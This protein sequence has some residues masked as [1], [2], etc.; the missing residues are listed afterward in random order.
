[1]DFW[2]VQLYP[3]NDAELIEYHW[4]GGQVSV[5]PDFCESGALCKIQTFINKREV[6]ILGFGYSPSVI[7]MEL[8]HAETWTLI[9]WSEGKE[10]RTSFF[11]KVRSMFPTR[12][13]AYP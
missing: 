12:A 9:S 4:G 8:S 3:I 1:M 13:T 2:F 11:S 10:S 6:Q 5:Y 7:Y